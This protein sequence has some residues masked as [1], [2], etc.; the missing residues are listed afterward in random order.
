ME[1]KGFYD[2]IRKKVKLTNANIRGF[3][4]LIEEGARREVPLN[5]LAYMLATAYHETAFTMQPIKEFG[6]NQ[7]FHDRYDINGKKPS[8]AKALGNTVPGDGAKFCGRGYVQLT[9][10]RNYTRATEFF[11]NTPAAPDFVAHPELVMDPFYAAQI[12]FAGM[13]YGWFTGKKL[14]DYIDNKDEGETEDLREFREARRIINGTDRAVTI[15]SYALLFEK[16]LKAMN[17]TGRVP[18]SV[19]PTLTS[20]YLSSADIAYPE[21][22]EASATASPGVSR[23]T[24]SFWGNL[25]AFFIKIFKAKQGK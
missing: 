25:L 14:S 13:E 11:K 5:Q 16:A 9:G 1:L 3:D 10:R 24:P 23:G 19:T 2:T 12:M 4:F 21:T 7:Y 18:S 6:G 20:A 17:Y 22:T 15:A 8:I